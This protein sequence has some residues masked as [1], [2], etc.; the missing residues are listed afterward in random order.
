MNV[1]NWNDPRVSFTVKNDT[2][3]HIKVDN[4]VTIEYHGDKWH[5]VTEEFP[6]S[7]IDVLVYSPIYGIS[8]KRRVELNGEETWNGSEEVAKTITHWRFCP[9]PPKEE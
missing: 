7:N 3:P 8:I 9:S 4:N 1:F 2:I 6:I 5:K